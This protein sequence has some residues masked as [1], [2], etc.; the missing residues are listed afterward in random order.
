MPT[1]GALDQ[2]AKKK[3]MDLYVVPTGWKFFGNLMDDDRIL[4]CGEESFGT[5][6]AHIREKDGIWAVLAW[7]STLANFNQDDTKPLIT[8]ENIVKSHWKEFGRNYY[9]R[10]DYETVETEGA[11]KMME[12]LETQFEGFMKEEEGNNAEIFE[13]LDPV[14]KSISKNQG[15]IFTTANGSRIIFRLSGTGSVG[16][17]IRVYFDSYVSDVTQQGME[18][19]EAL[20]GLID[21]FH[22]LSE[23][24]KFTGRDKPTVIT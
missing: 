13:Y 24:K 22:K 4:L 21:K 1:S 2:V 8:V 10:F 16:A 3:G 19:S 15:I 9:S 11:N 17:T 14:D 6:S 18:T 20:K 12:H 23:I 7:L 5:S